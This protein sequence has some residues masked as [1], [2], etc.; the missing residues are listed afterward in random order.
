MIRLTRIIAGI[1]TLLALTF[2][3]TE[4]AWASTC[5]PVMT[6]D[7]VVV[8]APEAPVGTHCAPGESHPS[9]RDDG[10][11]DCPSPTLSQ[12]CGG[13][14]SLPS[15]SSLLFAPSSEGAGAIIVPDSERDLLLES[16]LF[17]PPRA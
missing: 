1:A 16:A 12:A 9:E 4:S 5:V 17:R 6:G 11:R 8:V 3:F 15:H 13:V 14:V 2:S 7:Q 10:E